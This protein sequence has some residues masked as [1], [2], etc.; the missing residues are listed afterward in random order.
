MGPR[1]ID[2]SPTSAGPRAR[3]IVGTTTLVAAVIVLI[4]L[5]VAAVVVIRGHWMRANPRH[6]HRARN[7]P[8]PLSP[9]FRPASATVRSHSVPETTVLRL[10]NAGPRL[11]PFPMFRRLR[12]RQPAHRG[13]CTRPSLPASK[14]FRSADGLTSSSCRGQRTVLNQ[15]PEEVA[16]SG[17][18]RIK[19]GKPCHRT[20]NARWALSLPSRKGIPNRRSPPPTREIA[21][22]PGSEWWQVQAA[23]NGIVEPADPIMV[24]DV[25][26]T[27]ADR[28]PPSLLHQPRLPP[29]RPCRS[30]RRRSG[31]RAPTPPPRRKHGRLREPPPSSSSAVSPGE[32]SR[33]S[34]RAA[35]GPATPRAVPCPLTAGISARR[36]AERVDH[37]GVQRCRAGWR[38]PG[39]RLV[40]FPSE[41]EARRSRSGRPLGP[42][43]PPVSPIWKSSPSG[44]QTSSS[45][46]VPRP[47]PSTRRTSS[48]TRCP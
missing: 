18:V 6:R 31:R 44:P 39:R 38:A 15:D 19:L 41:R 7:G 20:A 34:P 21:G 48:P 23:A 22:R 8:R 46:N 32:S 26:V 9:L 33:P 24:G 5:V 11:Y 14:E 47:R 1:P 30:R 17:A 2:S 37:V 27:N 42:G 10:Q 36:Q 16:S 29:G 35:K 43:R 28:V 40:G 25:P 45:R 13:M 3:S 12:P 4:A